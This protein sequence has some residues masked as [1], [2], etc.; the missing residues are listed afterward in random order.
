MEYLLCKGDTFLQWWFCHPLLCL[1]KMTST[2]VTLIHLSSTWAL[3]ILRITREL[4]GSISCQ[5]ES[6]GRKRAAGTFLGGTPHRSIP[7]PTASNLATIC[8][9]HL[10]TAT[11]S[12]CKYH[13]APLKGLD[14][15]SNNSHSSPPLEL[16]IKTHLLQKAFFFSD[17]TAPWTLP[18]TC[19]YPV[20]NRIFCPCWHVLL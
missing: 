6:Q 14:H 19:G 5:Q 18:T 11:Q 12:L 20:K 3:S 4:K 17:L 15:F 7:H 10:I 2:R 13:S 9:H 8:P 16:W 1:F